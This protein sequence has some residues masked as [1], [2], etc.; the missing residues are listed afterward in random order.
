MIKEDSFFSICGWMTEL[1]IKGNSLMIYALI[2]GFSKNNGWYEGS[3][4]YICLF[5]K[6]KRRRAIDILKNLVDAG[7]LIK[8]RSGRYCNYATT[9]SRKKCTG[10][11]SAQVQK[12]H[13]KGAK[14]APL[15]V[16]KLHSKGAKIAPHNIED[17]IDIDNIEDK[18]E[19]LDNFDSYK[20]NLLN[21]SWKI[22]EMA[23]HRGLKSVDQLKG[24]LESFTVEKRIEDQKWKSQQDFNKHFLSWLRYQKIEKEKPGASGIDKSLPIDIRR[25]LALAA[26]T[27]VSQLNQ[28]DHDRYAKYKDR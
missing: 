8:K 6:T 16:Q 11:K 14:I 13:S 25:T 15:T 22:T 4:E 3:I 12:L 19:R 9:K 1:P 20:N 10:A 2:H 23:K 24:F 27:D 18:I 17:K 28:E 5:T 21:D 7:L 26:K